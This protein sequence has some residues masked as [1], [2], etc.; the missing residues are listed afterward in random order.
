ME[1]YNTEWLRHNKMVHDW[2]Q[3]KAIRIKEAIDN[4]KTPELKIAFV[5]V[6]FLEAWLPEL[7]KYRF[8]VNGE[9]LTVYK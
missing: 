1:K 8:E 2:H 4:C 7:I 3:R 5:S 9:F 6:D